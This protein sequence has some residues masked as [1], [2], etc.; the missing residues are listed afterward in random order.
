MAD[1]TKRLI[2]PI[3]RRGLSATQRTTAMI[4]VAGLAFIAVE[5]LHVAQQRRVVLE[6]GVKDNANLASSLLQQA[7]LTFRTADA[8]LLAT[9]YRLEHSPFSREESELVKAMFTEQ[10]QHA[11][12]FISFVVIDSNGAVMASS[13]EFPSG[14]NFA[15]RDYFTHHQTR[16]DREL[17]IAAPLRGSANDVWLIPVS[18]RFNRPDGSFAGVV[19][20]AIRTDYFQNLYDGLHIGGN[21]AILL[22]SLNGK[23]LVRRPFSDANVGRDM[24]QSGIFQKLKTSRSGN[25]EIVSSTDGVRRLNSYASGA[26]LPIVLAVAQDS[27]ELLKPWFASTLRR[28]GEAGLLLALF[29]VLGVIIRRI[30]NQLASDAVRLRESNDRLRAATEAAEAANRAKSDFLAIMSHEIRTPMAGVLGM[31]NLLTGTKLDA[32]QQGLAKVAQQ[33]GDHLLTVVNNILD[34]SRLDA[35]HF[36]PEQVDF[37]VRHMVGSAVSLMVPE[38][39]QGPIVET[40]FAPDLPT[41][42]RGDPGKISQILLNLLGNALKFTETGAIVV[43]VSHRVLPDDDDVEL[44]VA[45]EDTGTG[46][47]DEALANLFDPFTQADTSISRKYGGSGL[48]LAICKRLSQGMGGDIRVESELGKGSKFSFTVRCR[49]PIAEVA[50]A[51]ALAPGP[52]PAAL[53]ELAILVAE[54]NPILQTLILKLLMKRGYRADLVGN[55]REAVVALQR[56]SYDVVLMDMQMPEMDGISAAAAIRAL[57]GP[58]RTVP[59]IALTANTLLGER[60][61]CLAAG[62]NGFL[63]KPIQPDALSAEVARWAHRG[64]RE[65]P[66]A[67]VKLLI[68]E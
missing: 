12:Q 27:D 50:D 22:A 43:S 2:A 23:L 9:V 58:E 8:L 38:S 59:I 51:P 28:G 14:V 5:I 4:L 53:E 46:I 3:V 63:T 39:G 56:K 33:S 57:D 62:M 40:S 60:E 25:V 37:D 1:L 19:V 42:L 48:G 18:R 13:A 10:I 67:P 24:S 47:A 26:N 44:R 11:P 45:V 20:A 66:K 65:P 64:L 32:E 15:Q 61:R 17:F 21:G 34:F 68:A 52:A 36:E 29:V 54:D 35:G 6:D 30:T 55:G 16:S 7:E 49:M 31:I 41:V